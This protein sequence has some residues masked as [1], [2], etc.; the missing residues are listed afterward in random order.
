LLLD[1][2]RYRHAVGILA[3]P[4]DREH[5]QQLKLAEVLSLGHFFDYTEEIG[6]R[7]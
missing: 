5:D 3:K 6:V 7:D 4:D 1:L 2:L